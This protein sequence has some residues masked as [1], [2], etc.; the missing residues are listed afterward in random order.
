[1]NEEVSNAKQI[2]NALFPDLD[3]EEQKKL[4]L[5]Q[6]ESLRESVPQSYK[7]EAGER[8]G[9]PSASSF[10]RYE[11]CPGSFGLEQE[12]RR[13]NQLAHVSSKD[14]D[15]GTRIHAW[16]AGEPAELNEEELVCAQGLKDRAAEQV[17][18]IFQDESYTE[19][20]EK[21]IWLFET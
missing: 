2:I 3:L 4:G 15:R 19:L 1:M 20:V 10:G 13:L 17:A 8:Q 12:A 16:L 11:Q 9:Q 6:L 7:I 21:R 14:S 5:K 18:R